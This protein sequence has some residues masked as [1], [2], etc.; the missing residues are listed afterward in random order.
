MGKV[1]YLHMPRPRALG[2]A[3]AL[4]DIE[5]LLELCREVE[6]RAR[7]LTREQGIEIGRQIVPDMF[8]KLEALVR[9]LRT[10][11]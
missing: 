7:W 4:H 5:R 3:Y 11:S 9:T 10:I 2:D 1:I 8:P 6:L